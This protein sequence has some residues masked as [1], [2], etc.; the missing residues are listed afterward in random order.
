VDELRG[1]ILD[2][3]FRVER[4]IGSGGMGVVWEVRHLELLKSFA[5]KT[6]RP[7]LVGDGALRERLLREARVSGLLAS[8]HVVKVY[9][10]QMD[11]RHRDAPL[12]LLVME[13][14]DGA[15]LES[16]LSQRGR[17]SP[18]ELVW[19][20]RQVGRV[21]QRA[22]R[23]GVVHRDL[24]PSNV[25][26]A[27]DDDGEP[28][29][30]V[31]DFGLAK[32][33]G[34]DDADGADV[35]RTSGTQLV[36]TP[37]YMA[38]EQ[39]LPGERIGPAV[40]QWALGM[41]AFRAL[42]GEDYLREVQSTGDLVSATLKSELVPP[43]QRFG[44]LPGGFDPW[45]LRSCAPKPEARF[46]SVADQIQ[47]LRAALGRP[48]PRAVEPWPE[49]APGSSGSAAPLGPRAAST[50]SAPQPPEP[51]GHGP[52]LATLFL[53]S[54]A[55]AV[56]PDLLDTFA[57][58]ATLLSAPPSAPPTSA[59]SAAAAGPARVRPE[60]ATPQG[61]PAN[62]GLLAPTR[63]APALSRPEPLVHPRPRPLPPNELP[64]APTQLE[65][66]APCSRSLECWSGV[67]LAMV[68]Q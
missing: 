60:R 65:R 13:L 9:G 35:G 61:L 25:L 63:S 45:F 18:A 44:D 52:L 26:V 31:C 38:P 58:G 29:V 53:L 43:S 34:R 30:K 14:V 36:G 7:E 15:S 67:C 19:V 39:L 23:A 28:L 17:L 64:A 33:V 48:Q 21:L 3:R 24:K 20:M 62:T 6:L 40:D 47:A 50:R 51:V 10:V 37:R 22:H 41:L 2:G 12:P 5:V 57:W 55:I 27:L 59:R 8:R 46:A 42:T 66:G 1:E 54:V 4:R 49:L 11:H 16:V 32:F 56:R 68:C